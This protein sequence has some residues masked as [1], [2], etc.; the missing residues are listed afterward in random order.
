MNCC[1]SRR[2]MRLFVILLGGFLIAPEP[3]AQ[4]L[5]TPS[6]SGQAEPNT[7]S[8]SFRLYQESMFEDVRY[9]VDG[10]Y[11]VQPHEL[12]VT[13][14]AG[15]V[16]AHQNIVLHAL[17]LGLCGV[18][19]VFLREFSLNDASLRPDDSYRLSAETIKIP[20]P[21]DSAAPSWLCSALVESNGQYHIARDKGRPILT[22]PGANVE[23]H[24]A[25]GKGSPIL[26]PSNANGKPR[27][28]HQIDQSMQ[29]SPLAMYEEA[30]EAWRHQNPS[31]WSQSETQYF[32]TK[33]PWVNYFGNIRIPSDVVSGIDKFG[34]R[35]VAFVAA[36]DLAIRWESAPLMRDAL[37]RI[38]SKEY[39]DAVTE[40]S[41]DYYVIAV[42][43]LLKRSSPA[44]LKGHWTA[45]KEDELQIERAAQAGE[46]GTFGQPIPILSPP[47]GDA[48]QAFLSSC[49]LM[50]T[51]KIVSP[52]RV[53]SGENAEGRVD[54]L[55]FPR[56]LALETGEGVVGFRTISWAGMGRSTLS[57]RFSLK[58][59]AEGSECGL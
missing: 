4:V 3:V 33:S 11:T 27:A 52:S 48:R 14:Q 2:V 34:R 49:L 5:S 1:R 15:P 36:P 55:M 38:E 54:L 22:P 41:K 6:L 31:D 19:N 17:R 39:L 53:E 47:D 18:S 9:Y 45:E 28:A 35:R 25:H 46:R 16:F 12:V 20:L 44:G 40:F 57:V 58:R 51:C 13:I 59:M 10:T 24:A 21:K 30:S 43:H 56:D 50:P 29:I 26:I 8:R 7:G 42:I 32:L 37:V 23:S